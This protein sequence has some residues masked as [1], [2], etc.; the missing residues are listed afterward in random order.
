MEGIKAE[1]G[2]AAVQTKASKWKYIAP[3]NSQDHG[4]EIDGL[5]DRAD[6]CINLFECKFYGDEFLINK[7]Y[8]EK[9]RKK[10]ECFERI[11]GTK[12]STFMT[13][14]TTHGAR[15]NEHFLSTIDQEVTMDALFL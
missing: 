9:L 3:K 11:I 13:F 4:C 12:K 2:L 15:H 1:L 5:L 14:V 6:S 7:E 8:A 10:K